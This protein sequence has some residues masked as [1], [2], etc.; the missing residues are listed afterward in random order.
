MSKTTKA[1]LLILS[2]LLFFCLLRLNQQLEINA[3]AKADLRR[4][5]AA[6]NAL[7]IQLNTPPS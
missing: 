6:H 3:A 7:V 1:W 2:G 4:L 5:E